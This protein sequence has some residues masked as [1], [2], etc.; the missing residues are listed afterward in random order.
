MVNQRH[1]RPNCYY[2]K[3][4]L[5]PQPSLLTQVAMLFVLLAAAEPASTL[6]TLFASPQETSSSVSSVSPHVQADN[7]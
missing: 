5:I 3:R 1:F 4:G 7:D 6:L 2:L